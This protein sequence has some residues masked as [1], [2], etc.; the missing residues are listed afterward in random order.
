[1]MDIIIKVFKRYM[2]YF[3]LVFV[4]FFNLSYFYF[5]P[6]IEKNLGVGINE[7][8]LYVLL[9]KEKIDIKDENI[10]NLINEEISNY[11]YYIQKEKEAI[12]L[13][14]EHKRIILKNGLVYEKDIDICKKIKRFINKCNT[15]DKHELAKEYT[16]LQQ[17]QMSYCN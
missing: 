2:I 4:I 3:I 1:M 5:L 11:E 9:K 8:N 10:K 12:D 15:L 6:Y 14:F 13:E 17:N 7:S 16:K